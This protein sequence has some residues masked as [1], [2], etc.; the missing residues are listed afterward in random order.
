MIF[1][2]LFDEDSSTYT[3]L[4]ADEKTREAIIIDPVLER[5]DE[6]V[7]LLEEAGLTLTCALDTHVHADHVTGAGALRKRTGCNTGVSV[8]AGVGCAD[9]LLREGAEIRAG[10]IT[11]RVLETPGHT[12][13]CLSYVTDGMVFTG[14]ALL[15][16]KCGR[17]DFQGGDA[18]QLYDSITRKLFALPDDTVVYPGHD[19]E[20]RTHSTIGEEKRNNPRLQLDRDA[21][22]RFMNELNLPKPRRMDEAVPAN[23]ACGERHAA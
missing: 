17:T 1:R 20:G 4:L 18:G 19:Y 21:F 12:P 8:H 9:L 6:Y 7:S 5:V 23:R 2:Q 11:L 13:T 10:D 3:Y 14:D 16:G 22:I 15:I